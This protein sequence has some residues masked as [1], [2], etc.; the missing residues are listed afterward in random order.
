MIQIK[1]IR[2]IK[3]KDLIK[4]YEEKYNTPESLKKL[5]EEIKDIKLEL[6]MMDGYIT[7]NILKKH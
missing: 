4:E 1:L 3:G 6:D 2:E 5:V 7:K